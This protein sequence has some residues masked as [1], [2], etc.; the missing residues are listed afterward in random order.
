MSRS[1]RPSPPPQAGAVEP[2]P[3]AAAAGRAASGQPALRASGLKR[4]RTP[5]ELASTLTHAL[6]LLLAL[7][8][9][10][11]L[12]VMACT[13]GDTWHTVSC[14]V[15]AAAVLFL[16]AAST[17]YHAVHAPRWKPLLRII[18]HVCIYLLIAGTYT[19]FTL[20]MMRGGWGWTVFGLVWGFAAVGI[21]FKVFFTGRFELVSTVTYVLMGWIALVAAQP[22][23]ERFP[24]GC[25]AWL[26]A[27]GAFYT[28]G[29]IFYA[30]DRRPFMHAA[31][32]LFVLGGS[33]CH[34]VAVMIYVLPTDAWV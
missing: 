27:G 23:L 18:D 22:I 17:L 24:A 7:A 28:I 8:G 16:Y 10:P 29:V 32:H 31:W 12:V 34:Y 11:G 2:P 26:L 20:V 1:A 21:V 14:S 30:L 13:R 9:L 25:I 3:P 15:Y 5:D 19:P 6:G 33:V 4:R